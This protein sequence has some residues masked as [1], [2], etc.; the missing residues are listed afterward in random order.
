MAR[1]PKAPQ[2]W[3][4]G[5]KE[6]GDIIGG[7]ER[8]MVGNAARIHIPL[9]D[10]KDLERTAQYLFQLARELTRLSKSREREF[11]LLFS[12]RGVIKATDKEVRGNRWIGQQA[13]QD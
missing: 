12:A 9:R 2:T 8:S 5:V 4:T 11:S 1:K 6:T 7:F 3:V 13:Q 10:A